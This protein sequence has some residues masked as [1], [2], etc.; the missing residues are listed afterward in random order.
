M[1]TIYLASVQT[2]NL[3]GLKHEI[4]PNTTLN[5]F[6][7]I[8]KSTA[9]NPK[10]AYFSIG[11]PAYHMLEREGVLHLNRNLHTPKDG[12]L[13]F[14]LPFRLVEKVMDLTKTEAHEYRI[15]KEISISG[16][17]YVAYY[18]KK[19][20]VINQGRFLNVWS[21][22]LQNNIIDPFVSDDVSILRPVVPPHNGIAPEHIVHD[23]LKYMAFTQP[24]QLPLSPEEMVEMPR[25]IELL[26]GSEVPLRIGEMLL[27]TG[28][29]TMDI[30]GRSEARGVQAGTFVEVDI[31]IVNGAERGV[32]KIFEMG[33]LELMM[34]TGL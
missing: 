8:G 33:G 7:G 4:L 20:K 5:E 6:Y 29:E 10:M 21:D 34:G 26:Y 23:N 32:R 16:T 15:R 12:N 9:D 1:K 13:F 24:I 31:D 14:P 25:T 30:S 18:L 11:L 2:A 19:I 3:L 27:C 22:E 17:I 28:E